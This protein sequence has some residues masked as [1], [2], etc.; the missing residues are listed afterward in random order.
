M[1]R[2]K[3]PG[4]PLQGEIHSEKVASKAAKMGYSKI[5]MSSYLLISC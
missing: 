4:I 3:I 2:W 5:K 1:L